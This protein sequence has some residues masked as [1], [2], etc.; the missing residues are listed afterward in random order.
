[1]LANTNK[2]ELVTSGTDGWHLILVAEEG[3]WLHP[4]ALW[5]LQEKMN[6][7]LS[8]ALD[9]QLIAEYPDAAGQPL[10]AVLASVDPYPAEVLAFIEQ[11][12]PLVE[13][14]GLIFEIKRT[15]EQRAA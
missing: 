10:R 7:L 1:M 9:G 2:V 15:S 8:Y 12:R 11:M 3:D 4:Q 13:S 5:H 6:A 14:E